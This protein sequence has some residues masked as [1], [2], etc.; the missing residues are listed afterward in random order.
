MKYYD[1]CAGQNRNYQL[2]RSL[3]KLNNVNNV[4][5]TCTD[6]VWLV[7]KLMMQEIRNFMDWH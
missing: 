1:D 6:D 4:K 5:I 7:I 3:S 2:L